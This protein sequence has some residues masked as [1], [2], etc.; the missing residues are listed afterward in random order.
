ME[1]AGVNPEVKGGKHH[2]LQVSMP[3]LP[4][5]QRIKVDT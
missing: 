4:I 3:Q 5:E 1:T 2:D